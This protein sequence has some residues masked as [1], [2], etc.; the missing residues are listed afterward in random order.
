MLSE[1]D[2]SPQFTSTLEVWVNEKF[3]K[4]VP[5]AALVCQK[6]YETKGCWV[7]PKITLS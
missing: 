2:P 3:L 1:D 6:L 5:E 7:P 4:V